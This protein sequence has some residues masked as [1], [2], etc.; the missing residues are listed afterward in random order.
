MCCEDISHPSSSSGHMVGHHPV[1]G[2]TASLA[3]K[4]F[5]FNKPEPFLIYLEIWYWIEIDCEQ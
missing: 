5:V 2:H 1:E 3:L 4:I